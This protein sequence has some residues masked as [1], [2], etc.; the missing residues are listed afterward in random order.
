MKAIPFSPSQLT[1]SHCQSQESG[2]TPFDD[3][4]DTWTLNER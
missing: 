1:K 3:Q 4:G 2:K